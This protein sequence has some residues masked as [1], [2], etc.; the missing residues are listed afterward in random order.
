MFHWQRQAASSGWAPCDPWRRLLAARPAGH[1]K[2]I[3]RRCLAPRELEEGKLRRPAAAEQL[4]PSMSRS[5]GRPQSLSPDGELLVAVRHHFG[6][7]EQKASP[8]EGD[9][10]GRRWRP[11]YCLVFN[12]VFKQGPSL[13]PSP[14]LLRSQRQPL[15]PREPSRSWGSL[16]Q[17]TR[18]SRPPC[19]PSPLCLSNGA[20]PLH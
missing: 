20:Y 8:S 4:C 3:L 12:V 15:E 11:E 18:G 2:P 5:P 13:S 17:P 19:P 6:G 9:R 16:D 1:L 7:A 10:W 14:H